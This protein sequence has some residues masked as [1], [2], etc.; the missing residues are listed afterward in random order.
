MAEQIVVGCKLP[1]GLVMQL[2]D[3]KVTLNGANASKLIGG[4]GITYV[5]AEFWQAWAKA[6][7]SLEPMKQ[8][9][10]FANSKEAALEAEAEDREANKSG[11]EGLIQKKPGDGVAEASV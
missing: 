5:D 11:F 9:L 6:H 7:K 1:N 10:I 2:G 3:K 8:G 4:H